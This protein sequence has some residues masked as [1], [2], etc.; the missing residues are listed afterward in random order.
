MN[1]RPPIPDV[2]TLLSPRGTMRGNVAA[3]VPE[4]VEEPPID[5]KILKEKEEAEIREKVSSP[6]AYPINGILKIS[7]FFCS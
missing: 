5:P 1:Q 3:P 6:L 4:T 2:S 7:F